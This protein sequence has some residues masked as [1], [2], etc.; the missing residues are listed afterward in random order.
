MD[1]LIVETDYRI[2]TIESK[3]D[4]TTSKDWFEM[5]SGALLAQA[6]TINTV[7][8]GLEN[9]LNILKNN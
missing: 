7:I 9:T 3:E 5:L 8:T 1:K 2:I 4:D 6:F